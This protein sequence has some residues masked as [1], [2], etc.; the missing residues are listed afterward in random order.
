[1]PVLLFNFP[2]FDSE[3]Q[4]LGGNADAVWAV[5]SPKWPIENAAAAHPEVDVFVISASSRA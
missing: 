1:V 5:G 3:L 4:S 2:T